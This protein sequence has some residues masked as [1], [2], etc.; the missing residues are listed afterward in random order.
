[1]GDSIG[2]RPARDRR[3]GAVSERARHTGIDLAPLGDRAYGHTGFTG[4][5]LA[6]DPDREMVVALCTNR[7]YHHRDPAGIAQLRLDLHQALAAAT[8]SASAPSSAA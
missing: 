1:M 4:T 3:P 5:S 6:V 7:V 8:P 2:H